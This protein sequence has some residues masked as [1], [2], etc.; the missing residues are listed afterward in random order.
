MDPSRCTEG[1]DGP[2]VSG[3]PLERLGALAVA[4]I[5]GEAAVLHDESSGLWSSSHLDH[6]RRQA[7]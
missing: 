3:E 7:P 6:I 4:E 2:N 5:L 1:M